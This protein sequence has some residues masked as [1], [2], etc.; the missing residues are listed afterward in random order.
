MICFSCQNLFETVI[1]KTRST[2]VDDSESGLCITCY[3]AAGAE[4]VHHDY[5]HTE[6]L[7]GC[8]E[9]KTE[10]GYNVPD[11]ELYRKIF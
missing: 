1:V 8:K 11:T 10:L 2:G 4:T 7:H 6:P 9:C 3:D 5:G